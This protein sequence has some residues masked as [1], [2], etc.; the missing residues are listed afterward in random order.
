[1]EIKPCPFCGAVAKDHSVGFYIFRHADDCCGSHIEI[2]A[3]VDIK[4]WNTRHDPLLD[5]LEQIK[6]VLKEGNSRARE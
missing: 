2:I 6:D 4:R 5:V 3:S 1:M